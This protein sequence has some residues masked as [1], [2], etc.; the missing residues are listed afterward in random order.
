MSQHW[1]ELASAFLDGEASP[2]EIARLENDPAGMTALAD[3]R[4]I[5]AANADVPTPPPGLKERQ[6]GAALDLFDQFVNDSATIDASDSRSSQPRSSN[7]TAIGPAATDSAAASPS[8]LETQASSSPVI[9]IRRRRAPAWLAAAAAGLVVIAGV[10]V[11]VNQLGDSNDESATAEIA[12]SPSS[13][14][15]TDDGAEAEGK[16]D[17]S[18][19]FVAGDEASAAET[20]SEADAADDRSAAEADSADTESTQAAGDQPEDMSTT[21]VDASS[22]DLGPAPVVEI[23]SGDDLFALADSFADGAVLSSVNSTDA[24]QQLAN[25]LTRCPDD[26]AEF[27]SPISAPVLFDGVPA[28]L[29]RSVSAADH[30]V[31][32]TRDCVI[33]AND[34]RP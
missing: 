33:L 23:H 2:E 16:G 12:A 8:P 29:I 3:L 24:G 25:L 9:D 11:T 28:T 20:S 19:L 4:T 27:E 10:G 34:Q 31:V 1:D 17:A 21:S 15:A 14:D 22:P 26:L 7:P 13:A 30:I 32:I 6:L 18:A 5:A